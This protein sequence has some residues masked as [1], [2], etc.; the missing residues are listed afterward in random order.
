MHEHVRQVG[1]LAFMPDGKT[2]VS[3]GE[4]HTVRLWHLASGRSLLVLHDHPAPVW[5]L[6]LTPDGDTIVTGDRDGSLRVW[7]A[8]SFA[9]IKELKAADAP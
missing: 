9:R 2:L 8:P 7:H 5:T 6:A 1:A 4:D 3:V